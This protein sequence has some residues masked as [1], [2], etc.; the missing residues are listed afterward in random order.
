MNSLD[1]RDACDSCEWPN[2]LARDPHLARFSS[3]GR[4]DRN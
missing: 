4:Y 2:P 3:N 1:V